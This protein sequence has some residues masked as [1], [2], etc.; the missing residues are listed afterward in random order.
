M[1]TVEKV[2]ASSTDLLLSDLLYG[3][4]LIWPPYWAI[5]GSCEAA[6]YGECLE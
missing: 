3:R 5:V 2:Q 1:F 6:A 4:P